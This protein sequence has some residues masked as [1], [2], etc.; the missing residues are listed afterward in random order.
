M[1]HLHQ[2]VNPR[3]GAA[4][5]IHAKLLRRELAQRVFQPVLDGVARKLALPA[6]VATAVVA[7]AQGNSQSLTCS[8]I[9]CHGSRGLGRRFVAASFWHLQVQREGV[10]VKVSRRGA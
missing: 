9:Q 1:H 8:G 10:H 4:G 2:T 3:V 6:F 5:A 7:Q